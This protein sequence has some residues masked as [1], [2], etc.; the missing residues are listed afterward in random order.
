MVKPFWHWA[1]LHLRLH[2]YYTW[3]RYYICGHSLITLEGV[4]SFVLTPLLHLRALSHLWSLPYYS[5]WGRY[6]ICGFNNISVTQASVLLI[7]YS[8]F[9]VVKIFHWLKLHLKLF[10][11]SETLNGTKILTNPDSCS[12]MTPQENGRFLQF[13][14][15]MQQRDNYLTLSV[16]IP[17]ILCSVAYRVNLHF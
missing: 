10:D 7:F 4:T 1:L 6:Y 11:Y 2:P 13:S 3:G 9:Y 12:K 8:F 16:G 14:S 17:D 15:C 5:I